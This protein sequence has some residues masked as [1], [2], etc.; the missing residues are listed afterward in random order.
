MATKIGA[1]GKPQKYN[2]ENGCYG[3]SSEIHA[4]LY[5]EQRRESVEAKGKKVK[6]PQPTINIQLFANKNLS[7]MGIVQLNKSIRSLTKKIDEHEEKVRNPKGTYG[8]EWET[9][10]EE[11][12]FVEIESWQKEI[13]AFRKNISETM[14]EI[15]RRKENG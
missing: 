12:K 14:E 6:I 2:E 4:Q 3:E 9:F 5:A 1:G 10:S 15:K 13:K 8:E 7:K 11:R